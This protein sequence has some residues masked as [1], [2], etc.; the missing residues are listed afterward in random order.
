MVPL[1]YPLLAVVFSGWAEQAIQRA[2]AM[3]YLNESVRKRDNNTG[4]RRYNGH[5][6]D[7]EQMQGNGT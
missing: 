4:K 5:D 6:S 7:S 2:F 1:R 3:A